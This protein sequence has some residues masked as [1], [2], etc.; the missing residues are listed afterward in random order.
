MNRLFRIFVIAATIG[1]LS[2][3]VSA[4]NKETAADWITIVDEDFSGLTAGTPDKPDTSV[5]IYDTFGDALSSSGLKPYHESCTRTWGGDNYYPAGGT[6][7]IM[8]GFLNTP[9]GD[10]SGDL[11]VSFRAR[12]LP[13][14]QITRHGLDVMLIRRSCLD[15]F[16]RTT[17]TLT[18]EWQEFTF[19]ADNGWFYDT[20]VQ[21][22]SL[23]DFAYQLDD[24]RIEHRIT[25]IEPPSAQL[26]EDLTNDSF[27]AVWNSTETAEEYLLSV[28][29][30]GPSSGGYELNEDFESVVT[31]DTHIVSLPE[32]WEFNLAANGNRKEFTTDSK[33]TSSGNMAICFDAGGDYLVT[34]VANTGI[35]EFSFFLSADTSD[36]EY[37]PSLG[38]VVAVGALIDGGWRE[39]VSVSLPYVIEHGNGRMLVDLTQN[40]SQYD[41]IYA[42]RLESVMH[43]HDRVM[44]YIDDVH[45]TVAGTPQPIYLFEDKVI[46]GQEN[47]SY[48][49]EGDDFDP[50]AD[51][52]YT[53]KAR[54]SHYT[55]A[56]SNEIEVFNVH[57][58]T[59]LAAT[60]VTSDSFSANWECGSKADGFMLRLYQTVTAPADDEKTV[61]LH[62]DF[63]KAKGSG[64]PF[65]PEKLYYTSDYKSIDDY[66][67]LPGWTASSYTVI[68]G[69]LGGLAENTSI[70]PPVLAGAIST[71][72]MDLSHDNGKCHVKVR[73]W[74]KG[75]DGLVIRGASPATFGA[76]SANE[77]GEYEIEMDLS[78]CG[79]KEVL[80]F[81]SPA[82][83]EFM[84][85][86]ITI[87]QN[88]KKDD[89][90]RIQTH[91]IPVDDKS[92]RSY[93]ISGL[94]KYPGYDL[95]YD[96]YAKR[97]FHGNPDDVYTSFTSNEVGVELDLSGIISLD[98]ENTDVR[99]NIGESC[100]FVSTSRAASF[101]VYSIDGRLILSEEAQIGTT[102][103]DLPAGIYVVTA[104][105]KTIKVAV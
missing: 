47:T 97:N 28:Y 88:L 39:F 22:F 12:I 70:Y 50:E 48:L 64:T 17:Y 31:D 30:H 44:M 26:A 54:N 58:P 98:D 18:D 4:E 43:E 11:K 3:E 59:A 61:I 46:E 81:Y 91:E 1:T 35:T 69:M 21:F 67:Y 51:Y 78:L 73:G 84:I 5:T 94:K 42:L 37:D 92:A 71:P 79:S 77:D 57:I 93:T 19:K 100:I 38:Q 74:F 53:V 86:E 45:Y 95:S 34:P 40:L 103:Y 104:G 36:P 55:S 83:K 16:K 32:G 87:T 85:D 49:V 20:M 63:S 27:L 68:D 62:E 24:V 6:I 13:G 66:T 10:Y 8:G 105:G 15:E 80:T 33:Y 2:F 72:V 89:K 96:M 9:T 25:G 76:Y 7:A 65:E 90:V 99:V 23:D 75:G 56:H 82:Y 52:F 29:E 14:E 41:N 101:M 102:R 60:D